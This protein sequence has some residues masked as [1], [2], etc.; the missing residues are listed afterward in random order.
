MKL[1]HKSWTIKSDHGKKA[2]FHGP[3]S[4]SMV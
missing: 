3:T 2:I 4:W 1:D